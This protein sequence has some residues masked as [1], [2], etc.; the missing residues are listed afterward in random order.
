MVIVVMVVVA[1]VAVVIVGVVVVL[2][3]SRNGNSR[4]GN[5]FNSNNSSSS[6]SLRYSSGTNCCICN[7]SNSCCCYGLIAAGVFRFVFLASELDVCISTC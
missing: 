7:R 3:V 2:V 4:S 6:I 1:I 5:N